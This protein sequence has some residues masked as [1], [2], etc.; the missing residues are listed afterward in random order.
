MKNKCTEPFLS[1]QV[2]IDAINLEV[3]VDC[4]ILSH[5]DLMTDS[6]Y[7]HNN[8]LKTTAKDGQKKQ[9]ES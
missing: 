2:L 6:P 1:A 7:S 5:L 8:P 9:Q 4:K 3:Q